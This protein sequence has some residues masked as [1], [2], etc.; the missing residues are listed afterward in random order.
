MAVKDAEKSK[1][2]TKKT[3]EEQV[4]EAEEAKAA[5]E[6]LEEAKADEAGTEEAEKGKGE[7]DETGEAGA[8]DDDAG[9]QTAEKKKKS[10]FARRTSRLV[11]DRDEARGQLS[12]ADRKLKDEIEA[13][14]L[15]DLRIQQLEAQTKSTTTEPKADDFDGGVDDPGY[16]DQKKKFDAAQI[17]SLVKDT[18]SKAVKTA[19]ITR[20]EKEKVR[21]LQKRQQEH[22]DAAD[23]MGNEDYDEKEGNAIDVMGKDMVNHIIEHFPDSSHKLVY[24]FGTEANKEEAREIADMLSSKDESTLVQ[25]VVRLGELKAELASNRKTSI[26]PN[27]DEDTKG[28]APSPM[29]SLQN[30]LDKLRDKSGEKGGMRKVL[31]FKK[32]AKARGFALQ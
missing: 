25:G 16:I 30:Q 8:S 32:K 10:G 2:G 15:K 9:S 12:E 17:E 20:T 21:N 31:E 1:E 29:E 6:L 3:P 19:T 4:K 26:T 27:P 22:W 11:K 13:S 23:E 7:V 5:A 28:S 18:V 14:R 24:Y